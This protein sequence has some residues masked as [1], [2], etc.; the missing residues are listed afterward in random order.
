[1]VDKEHLLPG[2]P[3][4]QKATPEEI[5]EAVTAF[6]SS[7][8]GQAQIRNSQLLAQQTVEELRKA[9]RINPE[10]LRKP[11]GPIRSPYRRRFVA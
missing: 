2:M 1:M 9:R 4:P 10:D 5:V 3:Q 7:P 6:V 8:E 11:R